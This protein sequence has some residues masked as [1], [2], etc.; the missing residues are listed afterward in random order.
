MNRSVGKPPP[1]PPRRPLAV[2]A[3]ELAPRCKFGEEAAKLVAPGQ[4]VGQLLDALT[5][6]RLFT[7]ANRALAWALP[8]R[9]AVGWACQCVRAELP[10]DAPAGERAALEAASRWVNAPTEDNRRAAFAAAEAVDFGPAA[11]HAALA[12]FW[13]GG[14]LSLPKLPVVPP[15]DHLL[16]TGVVNA[17]TLAALE[18]EPERADEKHLQFLALGRALAEKLPA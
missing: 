11:A 4:T 14:S 18:R 10:E 12:A 7:D 1:A 8:R 13:S 17:V 6:A 15:P 16:P 2:P 3:A 9:E 5:A